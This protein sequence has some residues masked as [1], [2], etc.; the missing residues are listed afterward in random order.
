[1]T[2][3]GDL[4]MFVYGSLMWD[5]DF[6]YA[7]ARPARLYGYHRALCLLSYDY[8]GTEE[9]PGLVLGLDKGGSCRGLAYRIAEAERDAVLAQLNKR[10][11]SVNEY[12]L[13]W[14]D[15]HVETSAGG[16]DRKTAGVYVTNRTG[17]HY[18]GK[19]S[20]DEC[21]K[22]V[23]WGKGRRGTAL[24]YLQNTVAHM[25]EMGISEPKLVRVLE[26]ALG[27]EVTNS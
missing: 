26:R 11:T 2:K 15:V 21:V 10:E 12:H 18:A 20:F 14:F 9:K 1:M 27:R 22:M 8:R 13:R 17:R 7:E 6:P 24:E 16:V 23:R 4:W 19:P 3:R 5:A 25:Q